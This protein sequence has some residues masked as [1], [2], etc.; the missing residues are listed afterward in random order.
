MGRISKP[1]RGREAGVAR[2]TDRGFG[3]AYHGT[4][5]RPRGV[6]E[7]LTKRSEGGRLK[8][9]LGKAS[10]GVIGC[11]YFALDTR[12]R[13]KKKTSRNQQPVRCWTST[14]DSSERQRQMEC[15]TFRLSHSACFPYSIIDAVLETLSRWRGFGFPTSS[16]QAHGQR[17]QQRKRK[18]GKWDAHTA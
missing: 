6:Q 4:A 1:P 17:L 10:T 9:Y 7:S 13:G 5:S 3:M 18:E 14:T 15:S 12:H 11:Q 8:G 16:R 2:E